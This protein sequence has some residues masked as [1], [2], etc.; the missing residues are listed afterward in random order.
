MMKLLFSLSHF[1]SLAL[2]HSLSRFG[3][4]VGR[5][6]R[7]FPLQNFCIPCWYHWRF[8]FY[9]PVQTVVGILLPVFN[10][11]PLFS[12]GALSHRHTVD[13]TAIERDRYEMWLKMRLVGCLS[14]CVCVSFFLTWQQLNVVNFVWMNV[15]L[16]FLI[17][18]AIKKEKMSFCRHLT[19]N[20]ASWKVLCFLSSTLTYRQETKHW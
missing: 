6:F 14:V 9:S 20:S 16:W 10:L 19:I 17:F 11:N 8:V 12:V 5:F 18:V 7:S 2:L 1:I 4:F 13:S 3:S 15:Q